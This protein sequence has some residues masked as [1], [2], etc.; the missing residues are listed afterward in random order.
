MNE[1]TSCPPPKGRACVAGSVRLGLAFCVDDG[2]CNTLK[3]RPR[4]VVAVD[5]SVTSVTYEILD[6]A[7]AVI[8]LHTGSL[9]RVPCEAMRVKLVDACTGP[10][11][12][13]PPG[14][15]ASLSI[16]FSETLLYSASTEQALMRIRN[17]NE[18]TGAWA[19]RYENLD[20]T[21]FTGTLPSDLVAQTAQVNVTRTTSMG[22]AANLP[23]I[24][25]ETSRFDAETGNLESELV[26]WVSPT[27]I[28]SLIAPPGFS[29]S[30][31]P[32]PTLLLIANNTAETATAVNSANTAIVGAINAAST[33]EI[34]AAD[35]NSN[36]QVIAQ[37][38]TNAAITSA[39]IAT[40]AAEQATTTAV[41]ALGPQITSLSVLVQDAST[42][43]IAAITAASTAEVLA[44]NQTT[45]AVTALRDFE[46]VSS[47]GCTLG[48]Y[49]PRLDVFSYNQTTGIRVVV[50]TQYLV[51]GVW[52][53]VAPAD[54]LPGACSS[55]ATLA[56][57]I[58]AYASQRASG[59]FS[60]AY[61]PMAPPSSPSV[62]IPV[63][64]D[65][66]QS[67]TVTP[68]K[69]AG[70]PS[71][72]NFIQIELGLPDATN[73]TQVRL[74]EEFPSYTWSVAQD[75]GQTAEYILPDI[76]VTAVG[77]S[78][79]AVVWTSECTL[80]TTPD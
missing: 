11:A 78:A 23:Y 69:A 70:T 4:E 33:A 51:A 35:G 31:C 60:P 9:V 59:T 46:H 14:P 64:G 36:D 18:S 79:F 54:W 17:Y 77:D 43:E 57:Q 55:Q 22:C 63:P 50:D 72:P 49:T 47:E 74:T 25:R 37:T 6:D 8:G 56:K 27:G 28:V 75:N 80:I 32:D 68:I 71:G 44:Q 66:V 76:R 53:S 38:A 26:D 29:P 1:L 16:E 73:Y 30:P 48:I 5:C 19:L 3:I 61:A 12:P 42:A 13:P 34:A 45:N 52:T 2:V 39:G 40:V 65:F 21:L 15:I 20:G 58:C 62:W 41:Q 67:F 7:N 10:G 24:Q